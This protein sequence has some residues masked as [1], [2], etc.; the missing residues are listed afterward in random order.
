VTGDHDEHHLLDRPRQR[1]V[2]TALGVATFSFYA[3]CF[4]GGAADVLSVTFG[5][6]VNAVLWTFRIAL[7]VVPVVVGYAT[8]NLCRELSRR[9]GLPIREN[10]RFREIP[11][12]LRT[13][14]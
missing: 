4:L 14:A 11:R 10:V 5:L 6:S 2:R 12:R 8:R 9:D 7:F 13:G 1:P 3:I